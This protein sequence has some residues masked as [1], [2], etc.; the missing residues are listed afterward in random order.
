M[1]G[2]LIIFVTAIITVMLTNSLLCAMGAIGGVYAVFCGG[3]TFLKRKTDSQQQVLKGTL[4][5]IGFSLFAIG[6]FMV[7]LGI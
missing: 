4:G 3:L 7:G 1:L 6:C 2:A 5:T